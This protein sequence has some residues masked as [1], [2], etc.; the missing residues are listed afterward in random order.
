MLR[1]DGGTGKSVASDQWSV[2]TRVDCGL[3]V[4]PL[5]TNH[6]PLNLREDLYLREELQNRGHPAGADGGGAAGAWVP[7]FCRGCGD[8]P[9]RRG[10]DS[11]PGVVPGR[12]RVF[13]LA[14][15]PDIVPEPHCTLA[16]DAAPAV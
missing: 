2:L 14:R 3:H 9:A 15:V 11:A 16:A 12:A 10:E 5:A 1:R 6:W 13:W 7:S 4:W 8:L